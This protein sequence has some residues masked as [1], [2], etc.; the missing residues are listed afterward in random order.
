MPGLQV[1]LD[2]VINPPPLIIM[3]VGHRSIS[4][5]GLCQFDFLLKIDSWF[6]LFGKTMFLGFLAVEMVR[7]FWFWTTFSKSIPCPTK[8][9]LK[10]LWCLNDSTNF[11]IFLPIQL[12]SWNISIN[13]I[14]ISYAK[15]SKICF[16][17]RPSC[18]AK[19]RGQ[20]ATQTWKKWQS[21]QTRIAENSALCGKFE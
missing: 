12:N 21:W 9:L 18:K 16:S 4:K 17:P 11:L 7:I 14:K 19:G 20:G 15:N 1:S 6:N 8:V 5:R 2:Y 13:K 10:L 3:S